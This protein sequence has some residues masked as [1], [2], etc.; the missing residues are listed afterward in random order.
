VYRLLTIQV[1]DDETHEI[2]GWAIWEVNDPS[3]APGDETEAIWY[4][5]GSQEQEFAGIFINGLWGFIGKRVTR[6]NMDLASIASSPT[7]RHRGAGRLLICW[8]T[9]RADELR[10]ETVISVRGAYERCSFG[11]IE[12]L[13]PDPEL[14]VQKEGRGE[15]WKELQEDDLSG[16][17][18]WRP[19][20]R[21]WQG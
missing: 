10:I 16:W 5:R 17:L 11:C 20:R 9:A 18:M 1:T 6:K 13:P 14:F 3:T 21:D 15:K 7:H 12:V 8:G 2:I 19:V 4:P